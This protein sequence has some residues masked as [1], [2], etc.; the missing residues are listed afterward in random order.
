MAYFDLSIVSCLSTIVPEIVGVLNDSH[1]RCVRP[2]ESLKD[3]IESYPEIRKFKWCPYFS[4]LSVIKRN[5]LGSLG[6]VN[7]NTIC[8]L[9]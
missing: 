5:T 6:F 3:S 4:K 2:D 8:P 7:S 9:Y 1:K